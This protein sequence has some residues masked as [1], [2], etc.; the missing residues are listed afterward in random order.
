MWPLCETCLN[1]IICLPRMFFPPPPIPRFVRPW[2]SSMTGHENYDQIFAVVPGPG[3]RTAH[4]SRSNPD[5]SSPKL[6]FWLLPLPI[7]RS[8]GGVIGAS[9][10]SNR[11]NNEPML[12]LKMCSS[13]STIRSL[14]D[15]AHSSWRNL[16]LTV[17]CT[18][19]PHRSPRH[20]ID[21]TK[22]YKDTLESG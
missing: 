16:A 13:L 5:A 22:H 19:H 3:Y 4:Y 18:F 11:I 6:R 17:V 8:G 1:E 14:A 9:S 12:Q 7:I 15:A 20:L 10:E 21:W 2:P